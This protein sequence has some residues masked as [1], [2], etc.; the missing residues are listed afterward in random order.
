MRGEKTKTPGKEFAAQVSDY[1]PSP[2]RKIREQTES[3]LE[4]NP[5]SEEDLSQNKKPNRPWSIPN[6]TD[7]S[8][9]AVSPGVTEHKVDTNRTQIEHKPPAKPSTNRTQSGYNKTGKEDR[10]SETGHKPDTQPDTKDDTNW[11]QT[12]NK[13]DTNLAFTQL[14]GLQRKVL[15]FIYRSCQIARSRTTEP[16][17]L[18]HIAKS[19][20]IRTGSVKT[21][22]RRLEEKECICRS[23][24]K[25]GRGGWSRYE[26]ATHVFTAV[27]Q[28][29]TEHKLDTNRTQTE[30]KLGTQPDTQPDTSPSSS[31]SSLDL[32]LNKLTNTAPPDSS[33]DL[34]HGWGE[35]DFS[36]ISEIRFGRPQLMQ[37]AR[38]GNLTKEQLQESIYAFAFDLDVNGKGREINGQALNYFMGIL[39]RGPY[40]PPSNY[41]APDVRQMR[42][43]LEA[44]ERDQKLRE[45]LES[46]LESVAFDEWVADLTIEDRS[47]LVPPTDFAKPGSQGHNVQLKQHFREKVWPERR[48]SLQGNQTGKGTAKIATEEYQ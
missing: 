33:S 42:L 10:V 20:N 21:T 28:L 45:E 1:V 3:I 31:S 14:V 12:G 40:A 13:P 11:T 38:V 29:E 37:L 35:I 47:G 7:T 44:K 27:L 41:E 46:R 4:S 24:F 32:D 22:L 17:T 2:R 5:V 9:A 43:Y 23:D 25:N 8:A 18:E 39:R 26:L 30:H 15:L 16:L 6:Q 34:P 19:L 36:A 48:R